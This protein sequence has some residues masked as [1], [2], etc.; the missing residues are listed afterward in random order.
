MNKTSGNCRAGDKN[1]PMIRVK[2][3]NFCKGRLMDSGRF[4]YRA[5]W[6]IRGCLN[7]R[8]TSKGYRLERRTGTI[9]P[10]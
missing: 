6:G 10:N 3:Y 2:R 5:N 1:I 8:E 7:L 9:E 4:F